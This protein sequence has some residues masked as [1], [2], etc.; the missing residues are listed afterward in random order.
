M[1]PIVAFDSKE[2]NRGPPSNRF[3]CPLGVGVLIKDHQSFKSAYTQIFTDIVK[4]YSLPAN[5]YI[6]SSYSISKGLRLNQA[7]EILSEIVKGS[8]DFIESFNVYYTIISSEKVH[9]IKIGG[10]DQS[11]VQEIPVMKFLPQLNPTYVHC[12]ASDYRMGR[13]PRSMEM[14]LDYFEGRITKSWDELQKCGN[15]QVFHR[16]DECNPFINI[17]DIIAWVT[18]KKLYFKKLRLSRE[19][20]QTVWQEND[21]SVKGVYLGEKVLDKMV[22]ISNDLIDTTRFLSKPTIFV[23]SDTPKLI[24]EAK[25]TEPSQTTTSF[26]EAFT[27]SPLM[28]AVINKAYSIDGGFKFFDSSLD[29]NIIRDGDTI[30]H[31]GQKAKDLAMTY[32]D[33]WDIEIISG[34]ELRKKYRVP[35]LESFGKK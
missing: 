21:V 22:W 30:V 13:N 17:A 20:I 11:E 6:Y 27:S 23:V 7:F 2:F 26:K 24:S 32:A 35:R 3:F 34:K 19:N 31:V 8:L 28:D 29:A 12:C 14:H 10:V 25:K 4:R 9:S 18:D 16:G 15:F 33:M 5:R 1:R